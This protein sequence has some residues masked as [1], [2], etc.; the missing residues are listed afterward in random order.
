MAMSCRRQPVPD[1]YSNTVGSTEGK[2]ESPVILEEIE[3][4]KLMFECFVGRQVEGWVSTY[5]E[6]NISSS[7]LVHCGRRIDG[8]ISHYYSLLLFLF[9]T[10]KNC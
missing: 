10:A 4:M 8:L 2:L 7:S 5:Q 1:C 3:A 9:I 6:E